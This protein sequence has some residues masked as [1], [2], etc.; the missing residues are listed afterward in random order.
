MGRPKGLN[1]KTLHEYNKLHTTKVKMISG[2][3]ITALYLIKETAKFFISTEVWAYCCS[4]FKVKKPATLSVNIPIIEDEKTIEFLKEHCWSDWVEKEKDDTDIKETLEFLSKVFPNKQPIYFYELDSLIGLYIQGSLISFD[5]NGNQESLSE[6]DIDRIKYYNH[7]Y[8]R[9]VDDPEIKRLREKWTSEK[10]NGLREKYL[11][12]YSKKESDFVYQNHNLFNVFLE[13]GKNSVCFPVGFTH[14]TAD[15][16]K[17]KYGKVCGY[18]HV[19][20]IFFVV[21]N[22][23]IFFNIK[24]HY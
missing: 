18:A 21:T 9:F 10:N 23:D 11:T 14:G 12:E 1:I 8:V 17:E 3:Y 16:F 7:K 2:V 20:E 4:K 6:H 22:E 24:R 13:I 15:W 19:G 5:E